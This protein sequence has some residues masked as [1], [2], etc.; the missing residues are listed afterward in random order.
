MARYTA[1]R[2]FRAQENLSPR[3]PTA[4]LGDTPTSPRALPVQDGLALASITARQLH[5][6][7]EQAMKSLRFASLCGSDLELRWRIRA[8]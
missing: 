7:A 8:Q 1:S 4:A 2:W 6:C 3:L 5:G